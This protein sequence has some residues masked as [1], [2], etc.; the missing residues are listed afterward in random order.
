MFFFFFSYF[1]EGSCE[2]HTEDWSNDAENSALHH[3]N[4]LHK[5]STKQD[6]P[7]EF[8][9]YIE[10]Q[11]S[12]EPYYILRRAQLKNTTTLPQSVVPTYI[13]RSNI[14]ATQV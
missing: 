12:F 9:Q 1:S 3:R 14:V 10:C 13:L 6:I 8:N 7:E 5:W 11:F 4:T 2:D